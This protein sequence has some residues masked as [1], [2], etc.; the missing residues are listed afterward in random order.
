MGIEMHIFLFATFSLIIQ[1][2]HN[3]LAGQFSERRLKIAFKPTGFLDHVGQLFNT[4]ST[5]IRQQFSQPIIPDFYKIDI[6]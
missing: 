2:C 5:W 1:V 4:E 6:F 3:P